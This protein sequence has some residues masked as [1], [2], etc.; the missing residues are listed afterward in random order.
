MDGIQLVSMNLVYE[1][2]EKEITQKCDR[3]V[4][5]AKLYMVEASNSGRN[6]KDT[7][8]QLPNVRHILRQG[9]ICIS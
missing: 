6:M 5:D 9:R 2:T 8:L 3:G 4:H 7:Q 1:H